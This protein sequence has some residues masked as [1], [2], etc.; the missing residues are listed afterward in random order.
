MKKLALVTGGIR[1]IGAAI[2]K[3]LKKNG[4]E[5]IASYI[6]MPEEAEIFKKGTLI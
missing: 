1:G 6:G 4:I 3:K 5:V 2:A